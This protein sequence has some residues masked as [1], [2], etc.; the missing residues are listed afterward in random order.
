[1]N[2]LSIF[3]TIKT[4][5]YPDLASYNYVVEKELGH[6][7]SGGRATYQGINILTGKSVVIKQFQFIKGSEW[8]GYEATER[9]IEVL[10]QLDLPNIPR[11]LD[12]LETPTGFCLITE[13]K[14]APSLAVKANFTL[15]QIKEIAIGVLEILVYLQKQNPPV[16]HRDLKPENILAK[17]D[18]INF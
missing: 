17:I 11:Y 2:V 10:K 5:K 6:N 3:P 18:Q 16:I 1:M 9:E 4:C 15:E 13:Y 12:R 8:S 14:N 7:I